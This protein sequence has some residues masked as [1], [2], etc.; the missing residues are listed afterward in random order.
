M[1]NT[2][3]DLSKYDHTFSLK[4]KLG[5]LAWNVCY[6]ILFRPFGSAIFRAW[7]NLLLRLFGANIS[8]KANVYASARVWAPWNLT[9]GDY[10]TLGP[11]VDCYNQGEICVGAH[12]TISQKTYLCASS[13]DINDPRST[14]ILK[15]IDIADQSW[16]AADAFIGPGVSIGQGAV[17]GARAAV[18]N[19]VEPWTVVGGNPAKYIKNRVLLHKPEDTGGNP[20]NPGSTDGSLREE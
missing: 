14:L 19:D 18:F 12:T 4:N 9:L 1:H 3:V 16:I 7:R 13:H 11:Q 15:P 5:R 17:V 20:R 8:S 6:W 10:S 2:N